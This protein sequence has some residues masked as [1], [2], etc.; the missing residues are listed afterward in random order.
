MHI[1]LVLV[2]Y[3]GVAAWLPRV[4]IL[5]EMNALNRSELLELP[6]EMTSEHKRLHLWQ[7][8]SKGIIC[9]VSLTSVSTGRCHSLSLPRRAF[10]KGPGWS[11]LASWG[12]R[13]R[14]LAPTCRLPVPPSPYAFF[15]ICN[16]T[17]N[18]LICM[19]NSLE[20]GTG[21]Y[22]SGF[23]NFLHTCYVEEI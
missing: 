1:S 11:F 23:K 9:S 16:E 8:K 7:M 10:W 14:S 4:R 19:R 15:P 20:V 17:S 22:Y 21:F 12:P 5:D 18:N 2:L 13:V 6:P 3:E